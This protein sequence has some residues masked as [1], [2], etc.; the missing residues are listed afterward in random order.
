[1]V[2]RGS[3]IRNFMLSR[4]RESITKTL[5]KKKHRFKTVE[6]LENTR[7]VIYPDSISDVLINDVARIFGISSIS[8]VKEIEY[9]LDHV[10]DVLSKFIEEDK[11]SSISLV[12]QGEFGYKTNVFKKIL[13]SYLVDNYGVRIDLNNPAK[14]Y[15]VE[16]R[17]G[18]AF[19]TDIVYKGYGGLPYG[20]EGCMV[21][22]S[23]G[24][25]DSALATWYALKRGVRVVVV[26]IN[27][28]PYW[29]KKA[30]ERFYESLKYIYDWVPWDYL[31]AYIVNDIGSFLVKSTSNLPAR[32]KCLACK[33]NMY[34][35]ASII[36]KRE[37]CKG[38]VTGE[39]IGQ[40]ASQTGNNLYVLSKL[41]DEPLYRPLIFKDKLEIIEEA[42]KLGFSKLA[43]DVS[44]CKLRPDKPETSADVNDL[45]LLRE[46][47]LVTTNDVRELIEQAEII[48]YK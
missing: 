40:V 4:L 43:R 21:S 36:S 24:G 15:F 12:V 42:E 22:L 5:E 46:W 44:G 19:I 6:I 28:N 30:I 13:A 3:I 16:V 25:I 9:N 39:A 7:I 23:S 33:A 41:V 29:S 20:V 45:E 2:R 18:K 1:M 31:K 11:P 27:M 37:G 8:P 47:L 34:R 48:Y 17:S 38:I 32:L 26:F 35:I 10:V 14:T